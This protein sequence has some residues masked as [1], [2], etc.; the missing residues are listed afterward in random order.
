MLRRTALALLLGVLA[1]SSA[2][3]QEWADNMFETTSHDFGSIARGAKAEFEFALS[4]IYLEDVHIASVRS[5]CRCTQ[6][7]IKKPDL[8]TYEKSAI[9]AKINSHTFSGDRGATITVTLD[10]PFYAEVR[11]KSKVYIRT[12]VVFSPDSVQVGEIE[13]GTAVEKKISIDYSG[14]SDWQILEVRSANPHI[15][16]EVVQTRRSGGQV[17]YDLVVRL[18]GDAPSGYI[19][20]HLILVTND[21]NKTQVPVTVEGVV[22]SGITVSPASLFLGVIEPGK[23]VTKQLVVRAKKPFRI[24]SVSCDDDCFEF[25]EVSTDEAKPLHLIPVTFCAGKESGKVLKTI[26]IETD[27]GQSLP[28][29]S[30][31]A[32]VAAK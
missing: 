30:A 6:V 31:Y 12:D 18:D 10:K 7:R 11:L 9:V 19:Q 25:G 24:V 16:G 8:K 13:E 22:Q 4:N 23:K 32:V 5:S 15:A 14:R 3:G 27:S 1:G 29:L 26:R 20:D 28:E 2:Y 17:G 21:R